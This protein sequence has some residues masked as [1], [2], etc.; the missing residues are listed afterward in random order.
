MERRKSD[1]C[2]KGGGVGR[3]DLLRWELVL[4]PLI[5]LLLPLA[6]REVKQTCHS[7]LKEGLVIDSQAMLPEKL[8]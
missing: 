1:S 2:Q 4:S 7:Y 3:G 8:S 5:F 6:S